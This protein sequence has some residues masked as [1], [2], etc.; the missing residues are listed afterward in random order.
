MQKVLSKADFQPLLRIHRCY[1]ATFNVWW[2][3]TYLSGESLQRNTCSL[4]SNVII[5]ESNAFSGMLPVWLCMRLLPASVSV[6]HD[7]LRALLYKIQSLFWVVHF[8]IAF[9]DTTFSTIVRWYI[10]SVLH[11][12]ITA[13]MNRTGK[14]L[15]GILLWKKGYCQTLRGKCIKSF[16]E[17]WH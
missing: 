17:S 11:L 5:P 10:M 1:L 13:C 9:N 6:A 4:Q 2:Q 14:F 7:I 12:S 8:A 15:R 16:T 3:Q